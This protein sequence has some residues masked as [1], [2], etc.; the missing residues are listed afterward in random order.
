M[1]V[2][3]LATGSAKEREAEIA[4]AARMADLLLA[5]GK[6]TLVMTSRQLVTGS[7]KSPEASIVLCNII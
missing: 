1:S 4:Q 3:A 5:S 2:G 7:C 6:D